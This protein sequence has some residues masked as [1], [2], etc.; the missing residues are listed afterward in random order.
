MNPTDPMIYYLCDSLYRIYKKIGKN[1]IKWASSVLEIIDQVS[2][3]VFLKQNTNNNNN[4]DTDTD[5][6]T[7][8]EDDELRS[9]CLNFYNRTCDI[10]ILLIHARKY[11]IIDYLNHNQG[12]TNESCLLIAKLRLIK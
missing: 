8:C 7:N 6:E 9:I 3:T 2:N 10:D 11:K 12:D 1:F 5:D 4:M